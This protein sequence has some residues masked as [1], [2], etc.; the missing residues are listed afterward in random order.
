M[1]EEHPVIEYVKRVETETL[2][3]VDK[4][5]DDIKIYFVCN[6]LGDYHGHLICTEDHFSEFK[7]AHPELITYTEND[8]SDSD[9]III[10]REFDLDSDE[11]P[12]EK[13]LVDSNTGVLFKNAALMKLLGL[14]NSCKELLRAG[15]LNDVSRDNLLSTIFYSH[16]KF[17]S[18]D[19][20]KNAS[21]KT[22][23]LKKEIISVIKSTWEVYPSLS[24]GRMVEIIKE[25]YSGGV[26]EKTIKTWIRDDKLAPEQPKKYYSGAVSL[27]LPGKE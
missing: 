11:T 5:L 15:L 2:K 24:K 12:L 25:H 23:R 16:K 3:Y 9:K 26:S 4:L 8:F 17:K 21:K 18:F 6:D 7:L 19:G 22:H 13:G 10:A 20:A 1:K 14:H 27:V